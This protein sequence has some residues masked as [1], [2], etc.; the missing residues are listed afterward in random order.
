MR[1]RLN[2]SFEELVNENKQQLLNDDQAIKEIELKV[3]EKY[4]KEMQQA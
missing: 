1:K 3:E 2:K 4:S